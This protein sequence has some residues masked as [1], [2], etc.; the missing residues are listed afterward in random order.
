MVKLNRGAGF[1]K[2]GFIAQLPGVELS[3]VDIGHDS[4]IDADARTVFRSEDVEII[5]VVITEPS[6]HHNEFI[7]R[8]II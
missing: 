1:Y 3:G 2:T 8:Q 5:G 6:F 7:T 4:T